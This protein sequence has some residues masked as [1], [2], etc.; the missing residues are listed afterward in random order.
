[1][2]FRKILQF[3]AGKER[4]SR[5]IA[6]HDIRIAKTELRACKLNLDDI[7][8]S[9]GKFSPRFKKYLSRK[10]GNNKD[11][12]KKSEDIMSER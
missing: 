2:R 6:K 12:L 8:K 1:M 11:I 10:I 4:K 5:Y 9:P 7:R 3:I